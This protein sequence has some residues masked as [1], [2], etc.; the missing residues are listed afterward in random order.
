M[1]KHE[2]AEVY[3]FDEVEEASVD[4]E[5]QVS[6]DLVG[7]ASVDDDLLDHDKMIKASR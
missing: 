1:V 3:G 5:V 7:E 2:V 6:D 4:D